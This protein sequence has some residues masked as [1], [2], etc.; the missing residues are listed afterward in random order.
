MLYPEIQD[1]KENTK[2]KIKQYPT[3]KKK[4]R[5]REN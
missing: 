5:V 3:T 1:R 4:K 2:E